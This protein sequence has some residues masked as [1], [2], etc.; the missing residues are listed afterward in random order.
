MVKDIQ[1]FGFDALDQFNTAQDQSQWSSAC[2]F[3]PSRSNSF[4]CGC[5]RIFQI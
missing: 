1:S 3:V 5:E 4:A 2:Q